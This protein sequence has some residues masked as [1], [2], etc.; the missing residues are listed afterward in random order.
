ME[1]IIAVI[2]TWIVARIDYNIK[3]KH[4]IWHIERKYKPK[5]KDFF[6]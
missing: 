2:A 3:L 6:V 5:P 1:I 4:A